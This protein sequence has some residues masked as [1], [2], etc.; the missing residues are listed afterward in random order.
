MGRPK[1]HEEEQVGKEKVINRKES[2][3][4]MPVILCVEVL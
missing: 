2:T 4:R 3:V 1:Y